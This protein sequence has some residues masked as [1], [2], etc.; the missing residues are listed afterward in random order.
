VF[1]ERPGLQ[2]AVWAVGAV[3]VMT[4]VADMGDRAIALIDLSSSKPSG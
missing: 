4:I 1:S 2:N 3:L